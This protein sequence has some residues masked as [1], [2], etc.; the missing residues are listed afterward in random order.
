MVV[1][2]LPSQVPNLWNEIKF[3]YSAVNKVI[4]ARVFNKLLLNLLNEKAQCFVRV[5]DNK[6]LMA[7]LT[8]ELKQDEVGDKVFLITCL[9]SFQGVDINKWAEDMMFVRTFVKNI[10]CKKIVFQSSNNKIMEIG[11]SLGFRED[12]RN[13]SLEV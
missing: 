3:A 5:D 9:Y 2:L 6:Q 7:I 11:Q 1:K 8:T 13:Y 12:Y 10:G 4:D